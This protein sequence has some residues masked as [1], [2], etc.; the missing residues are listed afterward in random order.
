MRG[1][2]PDDVLLWLFR[3]AAGQACPPPRWPVGADTR[4]LRAGLGHHRGWGLLARSGPAVTGLPASVLDEA[5]ERRRSMVRR[6]LSLDA[7]LRALAGSLDAAG[8]A[9]VC[10][11][12][13]VLAEVYERAGVGDVRF[14]SDLD[15]LVHPARF[16]DALRA[17][18]AA[19]SGLLTRNFALLRAAVPGEL[20]LQARH[21]SVV[22]LHWSLVNRQ[23]RRA[24]TR[25]DTGELIDRAHRAVVAGS[26][27]PVLQPED[28]LV[29]VCL[30]AA[31]S[32]GTRLSWL[33]DVTL[34]I[35]DRT[36]DWRAVSARA[37]AWGVG[38]AVGLVLQRSRALLGATVPGHVVEGLVPQPWRLAQAVSVGRVVAARSDVRGAP[39][40]LAL[41]AVRHRSSAAAAA[42]VAASAG[43]WV[44]MRP[45]PAFVQSAAHPGSTLHAAG[46]G[47]D[48]TAYLSAVSRQVG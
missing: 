47:A 41:G 40:R 31:M 28:A 6:R 8:V 14:F 13:P 12:G 44:A 42:A 10:M 37:V 21:G 7:D 33:L 30:H 38:P 5:V 35:A 43:R 9:W 18:G 22:D 32:G 4:A 26:P 19:G 2:S 23:S 46:D 11:K 20:A 29:H 27:V 15:L 34:T 17:C 3:T 39:A 1:S 48:L 25:I 36:V 45:R 24:A 16:A